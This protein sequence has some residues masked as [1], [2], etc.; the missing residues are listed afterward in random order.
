VCD[1]L[2]QV[3]VNLLKVCDV[4]LKVSLNLEEKPFTP[5]VDIIEGSSIDDL[6]DSSEIKNL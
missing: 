3:R 4:L 5:N 1:V 6:Q 2:N